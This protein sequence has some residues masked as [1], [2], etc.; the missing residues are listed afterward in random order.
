[1]TPIRYD[2]VM[3]ID[4]TN[5]EAS[6]GWI[7]VVNSGYFGT[8]ML[9]C[10][11]VWLHAADALMVATA[12]PSI[13]ADIGGAGF[14][15]WSFAL[16][17]I[18]SIVAGAAS[19]LVTVKY[20][21]RHSMVLAA[22]IYL[23]GCAISALAPNMGIMLLGRLMQGFGGGGLVALSFITIVGL[24]PDR[25]IAKGIACISL[26]WGI[27]AFTGPLVGGFF[28][29]RGFWRGAFIFFAVQALVY[30][31]L[32][33]VSFRK[34]DIRETDKDTTFP[35]LR[36]LILAMAV[37]AIASAGINVSPVRSS[38]L[39]ITGVMMLWL[40][41]RLDTKRE[42][43]RL[44]PRNPMDLRTVNG[45]ANALVIMFA[46]ATIALSVYGPIFMGVLHGTSA[47][48]AGYVIALSSVGWSIMAIVT[49]NTR[50]KRDGFWI[51]AGAA[52]LVVSILG[53]LWSMPN[54]PVWLIAVF[55]F[56]EGAGFGMSWTFIIRQSTRAAAEDD[57]ERVASSMY[58][59][60]RLGYAIGAALMGIVANASGIA[61]SIDPT[62]AHRAAVAI[63][64]TCLILAIPGIFAAKRMGR[65]VDTRQAGPVQ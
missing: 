12:M 54:G 31:A 47:L 6:A 57:R 52:T 28:A 61:D 43:H 46:I 18:G 5:S 32:I 11:G 40:F 42:A 36:L 16:Y 30:A 39:L 24:L 29:E 60:H 49:S 55:A 41:V 64:V 38:I 1:M 35:K 25:L 15:A 48:A 27:S 26:V 45:S 37:V 17:E 20:G 22:L 63:F 3:A 34:R 56:L 2:R 50:E 51:K 33:Y 7:E 44:L 21:V 4:D 59:V 58:T 13:V 23:S 14:V 62:T 9:I 65:G 19:G 53:L 8:L 10:L